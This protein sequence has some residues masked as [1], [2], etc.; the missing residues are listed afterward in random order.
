MKKGIFILMSFLSL[1]FL[2]AQ[3]LNVSHSISDTSDE[4]NTA[5]ITINATGGQAPYQYFWSEKSVDTKTSVLPKAT[6]GKEYSVNVF[7]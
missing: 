5:V 2:N 4:L 1:S 6:E 7:G 3:D